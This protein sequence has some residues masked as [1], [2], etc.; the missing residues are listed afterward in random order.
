MTCGSEEWRFMKKKSIR[1][2]TLKNEKSFGSF[3]FANKTGGKQVAALDSSN[4]T[5]GHGRF[6]AG[7]TD[8]REDPR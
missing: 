4:S 1:S 7:P 5:I 2:I 6:R 3:D 8:D